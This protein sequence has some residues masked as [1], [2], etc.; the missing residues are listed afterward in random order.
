MSTGAPHATAR[1]EPGGFSFDTEAG[2]TLLQSAEAAGIELP[3]SCR[4]GTCRTCICRLLDGDVRYRVE[5]PGLSRE[6]KA[7]GWI[8][9]CVAEPLGDVTVDAPL[10]FSHF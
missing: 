9:P 10:A 5:W 2:R 6:E 3:S 1:I 7:E 8:L 4:N